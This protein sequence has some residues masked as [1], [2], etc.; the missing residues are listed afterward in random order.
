M[1]FVMLA[2]A[3][4]VPPG[5]V[6]VGEPATDTE[7]EIVIV[8]PTGERDVIGVIEHARGRVPKGTLR[9]AG[10]D[11]MVVTVSAV[12]DGTGTVVEETD[13]ATGARTLLATDA[14]ALQRPPVDG[15]VVRFV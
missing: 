3:A 14:I 10:R 12:S 7:T 15:D 13:L 8:A 4:T 2:V 1:I 6:V 11:A 9:I 5:A